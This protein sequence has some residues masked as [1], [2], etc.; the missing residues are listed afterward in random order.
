MIAAQTS[1]L[2][3]LAPPPDQP[4]RFAVLGVL[5]DRAKVYPQPNGRVLL[6]VV[7]TQSLTAHPEARHVL[8]TYI[9][10]ASACNATTLLHAQTK[11]AG[12]RIG[13]EVVALGGALYPGEYHGEDVLVLADVAGIALQQPPA[14]S[15]APTPQTADA[16]H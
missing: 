6:Q 14:G 9:Y 13:T 12:M 5:R 1:L 16:T 2:P 11:A 4:A 8:A 10:P 3:E 7:I 15:P